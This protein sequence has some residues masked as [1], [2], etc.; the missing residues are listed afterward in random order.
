MLKGTRPRLSYAN[1]TAT[2]ALVVALG[3]SAYAAA[4]ITGAD[5]KD[6]SLTGFDIRGHAATASAPEEDGSLTT[7]DIKNATIGAVD[8]ANESVGSAAIANNAI[9]R[10]DL[11]ANSVG[12]GKVIDDSLTGADIDES[13]LGKVPDA[14]KLNGKDSTA[15]VQ[16][17]GHVMSFEKVLNLPPGLAGNFADITDGAAGF[18]TL[19]GECSSPTAFHGANLDIIAGAELVNVWRDDYLNPPVSF[20]KT[21]A[22]SSAGEGGGANAYETAPN[23]VMF[24]VATDSGKRATVIV[25]ERYVEDPAVECIFDAQVVT[26]Q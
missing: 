20:T 4:T 13:T 12:S 24:E 7:Y 16:G 19:L 21:F 14:D 11:A 18:F 1:V 8:L 6:D 17:G 22:G 5:V 25:F 23:R 10:S 26:N 9:T 2:F 15:Y 3:G